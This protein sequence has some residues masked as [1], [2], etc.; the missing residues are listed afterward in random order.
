MH[1]DV[2]LKRL[3]MKIGDSNFPF[4]AVCRLGRGD[5]WE[6]ERAV[7]L[8][9]ARVRRVFDGFARGHLNAIHLSR[10]AFEWYWLRNGVCSRDISDWPEKAL[11]IPGAVSSFDL[12]VCLPGRW[13]RKAERRVSRRWGDVCTASAT[14][15]CTAGNCKDS[16]E[17]EPVFFYYFVLPQFNH[18]NPFFRRGARTQLT[19][20]ICF[21]GERRELARAGAESSITKNMINSLS[22]FSALFLAPPTV[23]ILNKILPGCCVYCDHH[24]LWPGMYATPPL[25]INTHYLPGGGFFASF[26]SIRREMI[27]KPAAAVRRCEIESQRASARIE[28]LFPDLIGFTFAPA[29]D[30]F[31]YNEFTSCGGSTGFVYYVERRA[32]NTALDLRRK[33]PFIGFLLW[34]VTHFLN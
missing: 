8:S 30:S 3:C 17:G 23:G 21:E 28:W 5:F 22:F 31:V 4:T 33:K 7:F 34:L 25:N 16:W 2:F 15:F 10:D 1:R 27:Q 6:S 19:N 32:N 20:S 9:M 18:L 13:R 11:W 26:E 12:A 24:Y 29:A 14:C